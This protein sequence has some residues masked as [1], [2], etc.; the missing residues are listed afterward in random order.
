MGSPEEFRGDFLEPIRRE[1]KIPPDQ[2][3]VRPEDKCKNQKKIT[4]FLTST[5]Q[6]TEKEAYFFFRFFIAWTVIGRPNSRMN[7]SA[8]A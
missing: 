6:G 1:L 7:P 3:L 2:P 5:T 4:I 8:S